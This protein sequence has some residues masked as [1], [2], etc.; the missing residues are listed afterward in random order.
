MD[1]MMI[2]SSEYY[3][4]Y[5]LKEGYIVVKVCNIRLEVGKRLILNELQFF[6]ELI[7]MEFSLEKIGLS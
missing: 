7:Y 3:K 5:W 2:V 6:I 1:L 4:I